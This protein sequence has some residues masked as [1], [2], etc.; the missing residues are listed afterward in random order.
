MKKTPQEL[1]RDSVKQLF[2]KILKAKKIKLE[3]QKISASESWQS[4][5]THVVFSYKISKDQSFEIIDASED[6]AKGFVDGIFKSCHKYFSKQ[7]PSLSNIKLHD[8]KLRPIINKRIGSIGSDARVQVSIM[9]NVG[10]YGIAE[11][12]SASRSILYSSFAAVLDVFQFYI[13]CEETFH[14]IQMILSDAESRNRGDII[15]SCVSDLSKLT[16]VN[17]YEKI[18]D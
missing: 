18:K 4:D 13:N 9:M 10:D 8:Y 14:R 15:Q 5:F 11:F 3:P 1:R 2:D 16:E 7:F 6:E 17:T 12:S